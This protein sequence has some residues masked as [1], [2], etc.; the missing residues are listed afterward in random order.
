[1]VEVGRNELF[2]HRV[3]RDPGVHVSAD[4]W[5]F[6]EAL[7]YPELAI[8][9]RE[10]TCRKQQIIFFGFAVIANDLVQHCCMQINRNV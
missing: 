4:H 6:V 5:K 8:A 7:N 3:L 10:A 1:V 9:Y 2:N